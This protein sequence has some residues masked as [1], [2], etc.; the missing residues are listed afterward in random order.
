MA[1][2]V[3]CPMCRNTLDPDAQAQACRHCPLH[4][5][6]D[7]CAL[8]MVRCPVCGYHSFATEVEEVADVETIGDVAAREP[9]PET[10]SAS[11][12][13]TAADA[14][15]RTLDGL[16]SSRNA[17]VTGFN[18]LSERAT[19]RLMAYGLVPGARVTLLQRRPAYI[20]RVGQTELALEAEVA[21]SVHVEALPGG[22]GP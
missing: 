20:L 2:T 21:A 15:E 13:P 5:L 9:L 11:L 16:S 19:R 14:P 22:D 6:T 8:R 10:T 3:I 1:T 18:G 7:G 17:V 12:A 4:H